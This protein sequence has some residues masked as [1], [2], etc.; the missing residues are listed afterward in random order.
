M[1]DDDS[2]TDTTAETVRRPERTVGRD[3]GPVLPHVSSDER[4]GWGDDP[5][6]GVRDDDWYLRERPPHHG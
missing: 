1:A 4:H 2:E 5:N 6:D 3:E